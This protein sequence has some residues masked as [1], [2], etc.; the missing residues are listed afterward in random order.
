MPYPKI[1]II[2]YWRNSIQFTPRFTKLEF[3]KGGVIQRQRSQLL[4]AVRRNYSVAGNILNRDELH[5]FLRDRDGR[6]F[7]YHPNNQASIGNFTCTT[8]DFTWL[9]WVNIN[10]MPYG[11]WT[12]KATF[13]EDLNP[14]T[15]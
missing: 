4:N 12:F 3:G 15:E 6:P 5:A 14:V 7:E 1:P 2:G 8:W 9:V 11:V 13:K 10:N